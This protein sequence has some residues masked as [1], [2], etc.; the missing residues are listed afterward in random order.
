[1]R[2]LYAITDHLYTSNRLGDFDNYRI[3]GV[4]VTASSAEIS[5][6]FRRL[7]RDLHPDSTGSD[8]PALAKRFARVTRAYQTLRDPA[9][10]RRYDARRIGSV[11]ARQQVDTEVFTG[12]PHPEYHSDIGRNS[13]FYRASDPLTVVQA[14][15]ETGRSRSWVR[16]RIRDGSLQASMTGSG[17][18]IRRRDLDRYLARIGS[19]PGREAASETSSGGTSERT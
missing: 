11:G 4:R 3:L 8:D 12:H 9:R 16:R 14:S 17:Y 18:V 19:F 6:A 7:V 10:R 13:D 2:T 15:E 5:R 1:M